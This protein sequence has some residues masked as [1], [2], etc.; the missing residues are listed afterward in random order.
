VPLLRLETSSLALICESL[1]VKELVKR[2]GITVGPILDGAMQLTIPDIWIQGASV[3]YKAD[4]LTSFLPDETD[5]ASINEKT[6]P[7]GL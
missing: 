6:L 4:L 3:A 1:S 7:D 5:A 2:Q